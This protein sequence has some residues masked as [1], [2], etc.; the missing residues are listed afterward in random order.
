M[1]FYQIVLSVLSWGTL[2]ML[3]HRR[4]ELKVLQPE[5]P[6]RLHRR[7]VERLCSVRLGEGEGEG[8]GSGSGSDSV[9]VRVR[10]SVR[11]RLTSSCVVVSRCCVLSMLFTIWLTFCCITLFTPSTCSCTTRIRSSP[12]PLPCA[13][14]TD[15]AGSSEELLAP[16]PSN[17]T[18]LSTALPG[19][20]IGDL[21][22]RLGLPP[23]LPW[24]LST[25]NAFSWR[26][27]FGWGRTRRTALSACCDSHVHTCAMAKTQSTATR[28]CQQNLS[29][30]I[31]TSSM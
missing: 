3:A 20:V 19:R 2:T 25:N 23:T 14:A 17:D 18:L 28:N 11:V 29:C 31:G 12:P 26:P 5:V 7:L 4:L 15:G 21:S 8:S 13:S 24:L 30:D 9:R 27:L 16:A 1:S 10:G 6:P 22:Q